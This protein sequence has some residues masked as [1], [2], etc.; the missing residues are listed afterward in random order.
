MCCVFTIL[1]FLGP[2]A[3]ILFWWLF[4]PGRWS[5]AFNTFA[6]PALGFIFLPW[7]TLMYVLVAPGGRVI[8]LDW[9]FL[10]IA[11]LADIAAYAGGGYG[12]RRRVPGYSS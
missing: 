2:R 3:A 10:G 7:T 6:L 12:N 5:H 9:L 8:G 1:V 4:D 11:L